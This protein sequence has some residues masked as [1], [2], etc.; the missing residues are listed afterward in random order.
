MTMMSSAWTTRVTR[1]K[2]IAQAVAL[3]NSLGIMLASVRV[4]NPFGDG[5]TFFE[6]GQTTD[7]SWKDGS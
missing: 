2:A 1:R 3:D 7:K 6:F 4:F 5:R